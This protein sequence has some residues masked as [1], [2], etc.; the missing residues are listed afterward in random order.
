MKPTRLISPP[1]T[2]FVTFSTLRRRRFFVVESYARLFLKTLYGYRRR[3]P[4]PI[5]C[6]RFDAGPCASWIGD[7]QDFAGHRLYIH[8]NPVMGKLVA[9]PAEYRYCSASGIQAGYVA[10][11]RLKPSRVWERKRH[12]LKSCPSRSCHMSTGSPRSQTN[13]EAHGNRSMDYR[14]AMRV[15]WSLHLSSLRDWFSILARCPGLTPGAKL[16]RRSAAGLIPFELVVA[17]LRRRFPLD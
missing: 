6:F 11:Q 13:R 4:F 10:P 5:A 9:N 15:P 17:G 8:Q 7:A 12:D 14:V 2:Y 16:C 3:A 1:G